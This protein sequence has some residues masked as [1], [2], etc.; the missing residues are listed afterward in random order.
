M[1]P[2]NSRVLTING[3]SSSIKSA[4]FEADHSLRRILERGIEW[5]ELSEATFR[6]QG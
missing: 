3:G 1:N 2:A 6:V 4:F 5:I